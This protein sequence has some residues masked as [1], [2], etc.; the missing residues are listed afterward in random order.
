MIDD[1]LAVIIVGVLVVAAFFLVAIASTLI[2]AFIG[3]VVS[4]TPLGSGVMKIWT[5]LTG[6]D[7]ELWELGAFLGFVSGFFKSIIS[8][9]VKSLKDSD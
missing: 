6:I 8:S 5:K 4:L 3:W 7:C 2:G 9:L 1:E